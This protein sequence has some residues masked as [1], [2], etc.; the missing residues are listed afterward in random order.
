MKF[1]EIRYPVYRQESFWDLL[2]LK[3]KYMPLK[4]LICNRLFIY[5][6][7][8][9]NLREDCTCLSCRSFNRQ[10]QI[11]CVLISTVLNRNPFLSSLKSFVPRDDLHVYYT[12]SK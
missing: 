1:D 4:C 3:I 2:A 11:S 8:G 12:E 7:K 10:R 5:K 9:K 6:I